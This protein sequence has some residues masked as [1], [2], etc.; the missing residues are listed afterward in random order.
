MALSLGD[1]NR[2]CSAAIKAAE[3]KNIKLSVAVCDAGGK[4][5]AFQRMEG[6]I[7]ISADV[8]IGKA[9]GS[10]GFGRAS[11]DIPAD[12][13]VIQAVLATQGGKI[14]PA[15]GAVPIIQSGNIVG[16]IG[17]SGGTSQEDEDCARIG[18][19]AL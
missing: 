11:G 12:N 3:D 1:A 9:V 7:F 14:V 13:P 16:S 4:L 10:V 17:G 19:A 18:M 5:L 8:A 15:Q 6:A 2:M